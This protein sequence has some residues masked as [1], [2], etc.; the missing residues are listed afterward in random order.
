MLQLALIWALTYAC[1]QTG[2][3]FW[4]EFAVGERGFSDG[5]V[6]LSI[7]IAALVAMPLVFYSGRLLDLIGRRPG[8]AVIFLSGAAGMFA[9]YTLDGYWPLT[10][11]LTFGIT[12]ASAVLPVLTIPVISSG[13][14]L[15]R[16]A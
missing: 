8:A 9:S 11:A 14:R 16:A 4:K 6:G 3:T 2:V 1:T 15:A 7:T 10:I 12:G 13:L 5:Q